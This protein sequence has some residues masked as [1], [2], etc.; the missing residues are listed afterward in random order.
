MIVPSTSW[1]QHK[2]MAAVKHSPQFAARVGVPQSV[3][4]DFIAAD[5]KAGI[6]KT[7]GGKPNPAFRRRLP[8]ARGR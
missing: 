6:S 4:Q 1:K 7:V 3:G 8:N 5:D 2:F